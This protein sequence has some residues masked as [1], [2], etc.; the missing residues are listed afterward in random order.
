ME[1][2]STQIDGCKSTRVGTVSRPLSNT[3]WVAVS[4]CRRSLR[5]EEAVWGGVT[6]CDC[7]VFLSLRGRSG[8]KVF[9]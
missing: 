8:K 4:G 2:V 7:L 3:P 6:C 1:Y 9:Y 5:G